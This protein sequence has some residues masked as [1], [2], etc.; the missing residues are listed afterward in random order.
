MSTQNEPSYPTGTD[1]ESVGKFRWYISSLLFVS[2][3][4][5]YYDRQIPSIAV[6][7]QSYAREIGF[8]TADG[9]VDKVLF[10]Y[11]DSAHKIAYALGFLLMGRFLDWIGLKR[12]FAIGVG[13]WSCATIAFVLLH[14]FWPLVFGMILM[15]FFQASDHPGCVKTVS[16]WFPASERSVAVAF[17]N[18]GTNF[19]AIIVSYLV[20]LVCLSLSWQMGYV[21]PGLL[22]L[23][24]VIV[25]WFT[26]DPPETNRFVGEAERR[27]IASGRVVVAETRLGW[28][29]LFTSRSA[30]GF[31]AAKL[32]TDPVWFLYLS[33]LPMYFNERYHVNI[34]A[35]FVPITL[36]YV[37]SLIG[38]FAG[39]G[40]SSYLLR[41]GWTINR[42][43]KGAMLLFALMAVPAFLAGFTSSV[44][45]VVAIVGWV[46][47]AHQ[48]F[49][50]L[51]YTTVTDVF[52]KHVVGSVTGFGSMFGAIGGAIIT[53]S[54]GYIAKV[55]GYTPLFFL[56]TF[57]Y[58][59]GLGILHALNPRLEPEKL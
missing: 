29:R 41:K 14:S 36:V 17:Y 37:L 57:A 21:L 27:H 3:T 33:W 2:T 50:T 43:R 44:W 4:L 51:L 11:I 48:A 8:L 55:F 10:G 9:K 30:W 38:N 26:F 42:A 49:S 16:G 46:T 56:G 52:P 18:S 15:G 25:W 34:K 13:M 12:G 22:G 45:I 53:I 20:P 39:G 28:G 35:L 31:A 1:K 24:W 40:L 32:L 7:I 23:V 58:L 54:A 19:G 6:N 47:F 5:Y 59:T